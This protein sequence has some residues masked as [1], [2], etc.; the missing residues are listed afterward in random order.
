MGV[1]NTAFHHGANLQTSINRPRF[2]DFED[3]GG[4][5]PA[6]GVGLLA[7][8]KTKLGVGKIS[9]DV[10]LANGSHITDR[11]LDFGAYNDDNSGKMLG[12]NLG[13]SFAGSLNGL[14]VGAHG[15][16]TTVNVYDT[17]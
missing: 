8:G 16:G 9:Y 17:T 5:V 4:V 15:F 6:H 2:I 12:F 13:Y 3:K 14:T 11:T 7:S 1:W 10:Y